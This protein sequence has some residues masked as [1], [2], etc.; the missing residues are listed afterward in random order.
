ML[1]SFAKGWLGNVQR[2][3]TRAEPLHGSLNPLFCDVFIAVRCG[4]CNVPAAVVYKS[5]NVDSV[6]FA[7]IFAI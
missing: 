1:S 6:L 3:V 2:F 4:L 7:S 5:H